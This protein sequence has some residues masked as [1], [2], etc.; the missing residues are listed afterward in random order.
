MIIFLLILLCSIAVNAQQ[1]NLP[2]GIS[3]DT[4]SNSYMEGH[5]SH[6]L[7]KNKEI[8]GAISPAIWE[9]ND[10]N[11]IHITTSYQAEFYG[12]RSM[13]T[14][15]TVSEGLNWLIPVIEAFY[16]PVVVDKWKKLRT[17]PPKVILEYPW[18]WSYRL[19]K[20]PIFKSKPASENKLVLIKE[21]GQ[22]RSEIIQIICTPN[23]AKLT[24]QQVMDMC[25]QMNMAINFQQNPPVDVT[26]GG[27]TFKTMQH[28]FM[29]H[30]Q[31]LHYWYA[32]NDEIIYIS[33]GLLKDERIRFPQVV[34]HIINSINW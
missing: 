20:Y 33:A 21:E 4:I 19:E 16:K 15:A 29:Q 10:S 14:F 32:D 12:D 7:Y 5:I 34:Q 6:Y 23:T 25:A 1:N 18:D 8:I 3:M 26:I 28:A 24:T 22:N 2:E 9:S 30:M 31:Q 17:Q 11:Y 13:D 27:K